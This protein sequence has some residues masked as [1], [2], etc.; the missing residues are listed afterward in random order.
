MVRV[1]M[2]LTLMAS[3]TMLGGDNKCPRYQSWSV[4]YASAMNAT[5]DDVKFFNKAISEF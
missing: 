1:V 2:V 3:L 5:I 4:R